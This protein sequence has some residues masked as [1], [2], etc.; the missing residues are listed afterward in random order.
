M[1]SKEEL[2]HWYATQDPWQYETTQ[3]DIV[4]KQ[5]LLEILSQI[6]NNKLYDRALD[7]GAGEGFVTTSLP[8]KEIFGIEISDRAASRLPSNVKRLL[9]PEG[10]FDLVMTTGTLYQLNDHA[11]IAQSIKE[12]SS[13]HVLIAGIKDWLIK[14]TFGNVIYEVEFP[15]RQYT[16]KVTVYEVS[17]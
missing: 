15:Y 13:K 4:R 6:N 12:S 9:E 17:P 8:A 14:Y 5:K 11:K 7:I 1:P 2:E 16:Q 10:K 3:D